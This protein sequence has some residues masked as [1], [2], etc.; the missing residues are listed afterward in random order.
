M[1][2]WVIVKPFVPVSSHLFLEKIVNL[3]SGQIIISKPRS[4]KWGDFRCTIGGETTISINID[5]N[6]ESF[7]ITL[8]HEMAHAQVHSWDNKYAKAHGKEWKKRFQHLLIPFINSNVFND[9]LKKAL[10]RQINSL[11]ATCAANPDL[12]K[13]LRT[14][15]QNNLTV[16]EL[17]LGDHFQTITGN[18][19][20]LGVK[21]RTRFKCTD[22]DSGHIFT[23]HPLTEVKL[24]KNA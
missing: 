6:E 2:N 11:K 8:L 12:L 20:K 9:D 21:R 23:V 15:S 1:C 10:D 19:Y 4:S 17:I 13:A 22:L 18:K 3:Y 5:L 14:N 7:L 16:E 24:L